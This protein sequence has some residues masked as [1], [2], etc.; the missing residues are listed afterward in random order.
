MVEET[1]AGKGHGHTVFIAAFDHG[2]VTDRA[3]G[4]GNVL[5]AALLSALDIIAE[6]EEGI[7]TKG[8]AINGSEVGLCLFI[9][10]RL[11]LAGEVLLPVAVCANVL[12]ILIDIAVDHVV[13]IGAAKG[14]LKGQVQHLFMLAQEPSISLAACQARAMDTGLLTGTNT[15]RLPIYGEANGVG[16]G[17]FQ[18][19]ERNDQIAHVHLLTI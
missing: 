3:T 2:I 11:G 7:R 10:Q 5:N 9:G 8:N 12:F 16:L 13:A 18:G 19:D 6:R 15:D 14:I 1:H 17:I 4:L